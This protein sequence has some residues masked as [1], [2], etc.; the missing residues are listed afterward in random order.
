MLIWISF[1][2]YQWTFKWH[3]PRTIA[4]SLLVF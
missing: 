1:F 3:T 2:N 4:F